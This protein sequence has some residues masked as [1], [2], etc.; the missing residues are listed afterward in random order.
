M[1]KLKLLLLSFL[2]SSQVFADPIIFNVGPNNPTIGTNDT[3]FGSDAWSNPG[4][5]TSSDNLYATCNSVDGN[6]TNYLKG[7]AYGF[8]I[9]T[10]ALIQGIVVEVEKKSNVNPIVDAVAK[11]VKNGV[12]TGTE[13]KKSGSWPTSDTVFSYGSSVD[14]WGT[15]WSAQDINNSNFGFVISGFNA[16]T[17]A[18]IVSVDHIRI[19]VYYIF[20]TVLYKS[21]MQ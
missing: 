13:H 9:P 12:I 19:T 20:A 7:S 15:N 11:I 4:N 2:L 1:K 6:N 18:I 5:I 10:G 8:N 17:G 21:R 3:S 14:L 16:G